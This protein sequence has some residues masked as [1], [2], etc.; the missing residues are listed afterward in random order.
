MNYVF[1]VIMALIAFFCLSFGFIL[2]KMG[3]NWMGWKESK[4]KIYYKNLFIW[5]TGLIIA[6]IYGIPSA[7]ALKN[8][9]P[10]MVSVFAG[11]GIVVLIYLSYFLL[12]EKIFK[13][14]YLFSFLIIL[15]IFLLSYF[16]QESSGETIQPIGIY[17][18]GFIPIVLFLFGFAKKITNPVKTAIYGAVSGFSAGLMIIFL[19]IL[20][21]KYQY[22]VG[23]Y[24]TS[25][26][27]Y[28]YIIFAL[29]SFVALQFAFKH[30]P[31]MITGPAQYSTTIIYPLFAAW[32][33][34]HDQ[35]NLIQLILIGIISY[36]VIMIMKKR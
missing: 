15:G 36:S 6:N 16:K 34:F 21:L 3:I 2:M 30:G 33:I 11:W 4:N 9:P 14:D 35:I 32:L 12:K 29:L 5:I 1:S 13:T 7:L 10:H 18:L 26:F 25:P 22:Q 24:F 19:R 8:L 31:M 28:L 20:V 17:I 27:S 23:L